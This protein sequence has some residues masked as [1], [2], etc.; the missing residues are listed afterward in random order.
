LDKIQKLA[1]KQLPKKG[2]EN[3]F[4]FYYRLQLLKQSR[5]SLKNGNF[6]MSS[7]MPLFAFA[8][9]PTKLLKSQKHI[10]LVSGPFLQ[11]HLFITG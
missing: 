1:P 8:M 7:F 9:S 3:F 11:K 2:E 10:E 4:L 6:F 5:N